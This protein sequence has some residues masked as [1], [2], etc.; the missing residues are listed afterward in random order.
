WNNTASNPYANKKLSNLKDNRGT[1][2]SISL[3]FLSSWGGAGYNSSATNSIHSE[4]VA[5][6]YYWTNYGKETL[7]ISGLDKSSKYTF[8]F[9]GYRSGSGDRTTDYIIGS[10]KVSLN[11]SNNTSNSVKIS[12]V[13]PDANGEV[14][15][16]VKKGTTSSF[17]Y[18]NAMVI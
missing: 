2:T 17:G 18:L 5:K 9:Y 12:D 1:T 13:S 3:T 8:E 6:T 15:I 10:N 14:T 16:T 4:N 11:A 7:K